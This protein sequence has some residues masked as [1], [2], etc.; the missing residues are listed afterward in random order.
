VKGK[1]EIILAGSGG[2]GLGLSGQIFAEASMLE[3]NC[4]AAHNQ[5]F[6]GQARG[7]ASQSSLILSCEEI[8]Y[9][10]VTSADLL[11]ALTQKAYLEYESQVS[12]TG[13]IVFDTSVVT[14]LE[15]RVKEVGY[16]FLSEALKLNNS[17]G[18]TLM[19]IGS[20]NELL[21]IVSSKF[22][23]QALELHFKD[24]SLELNRAAFDRGRTL[25]TGEPR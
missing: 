3:T 2:Q 1:W 21:Q 17:K 25:V 15:K 16:P 11:I 13:I 6:G 22:F 9:P 8:L 23:H 18:I 19:A 5:S 24:K 10:N 4:F 12:E 20:A 7:G 14:E